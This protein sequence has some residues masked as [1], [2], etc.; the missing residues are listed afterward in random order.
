MRRVSVKWILLAGTFLGFSS[1]GPVRLEINLN[2]SYS[3]DLNQL[4]TAAL[5]E[6]RPL[7]VRT[8]YTYSS[9][10]QKSFVQPL[11]AQPDG[12]PTTPRWETARSQGFNYRGGEYYLRGIPFGFR[13][14]EII[15]EI[16]QQGRDQLWFVIGHYCW[17]PAPGKV[18]YADDLRPYNGSVLP[19]IKGR[20]CGKCS[21]A[22]LL[23]TPFDSSTDVCN[24]GL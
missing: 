8:I 22:E 13:D 7:G 23:P 4:I 2:L 12:S 15:I 14:V 18:L 17:P 19:L 24:D 16:L 21:D 10:G 20:S 3:S 5:Q 6:G 1:C 9:S 11:S